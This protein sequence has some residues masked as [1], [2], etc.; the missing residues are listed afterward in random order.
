MRRCC[1]S[2]RHG[3]E[4]DERLAGI[5]REIRAGCAVGVAPH[6]EVPVLARSPRRHRERIQ[7]R[8]PL[9]VDTL[10]LARLVRALGATPC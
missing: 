1:G 8:V 2:S 4:R 9:S 5:W 7:L 10:Q 3:E 6:R